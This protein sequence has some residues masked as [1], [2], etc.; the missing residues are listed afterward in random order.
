MTTREDIVAQ[1]RKCLDAGTSV[2]LTGPPGI[3]LSTLLANVV[4]SRPAVRMASV[5][6]EACL[7]YVGVIDL[8]GLLPS[9]EHTDAVDAL[10][11]GASPADPAGELAVRLA[12]LARL[13]ASGPVLLVLD[14]AQWLDPASRAVLAFVAR[15]LTGSPVTMLVAEHG[16][17]TAIDICPPE[18]V[19]FA[20]AAMNAAELSD[21]LRAHT[22]LDGPVLDR[23]HAAS[24]GRIG[25]AI[26]LGQ[27][28]TVHG[29]S[30]DPL[31]IPASVRATDGEQLASLP[32]AS[33]AALLLLAA[34]GPGGTIP[35]R[36]FSPKAI[37]GLDRAVECGVLRS[38]DPVEFSHPIMREMVYADAT[39]AAR[40]AA[41]RRLAALNTPPK[42]HLWHRAVGTA[43]ADE[44]LADQLA[45][46]AAQARRAGAIVDAA[47]LASLAAARTPP[48]PVDRPAAR[49]LVAAEAAYAAGWLAN[50]GR[51][52]HEALGAT[53]N[54]STRTGA[55][56]LLAQLATDDRAAW[57][58]LDDA[59]TGT[60]CVADTGRVRIARAAFCYYHGDS[61]AGLAEI[62]AAEAASADP[63]EAR[64]WRTIMEGSAGQRPRDDH[65]DWSNALGRPLHQGSA[66]T[67]LRQYA[68]TAKLYRGDVADAINAI[69]E[70]RRQVEQSGTRRD[71]ATVLVSE[72]AI[73][74]RAGRGAQARAA[75]QACV[76]LYQDL[77]RDCRPGWVAAAVGELA[78]GSPDRAVR[79]ADAA[80]A[81]S[82]SAGDLEW[83][84][85]AS[86]LVGQ[87]HLVRDD[88]GAAVAVL[89]P[90]YRLE[91]QL[92]RDDPALLVWHADFVEALARTGAGA[93]AADVLATTREHADR[94]GRPVV[95]LG[96]HR[97]EAALQASNGAARE[98][99]DSLRA[100]LAGS[101]SHPYPLEVARAWHVLGRL[102]RRAHRRSAARTALAEAV[103]R[104]AAL[105][106][107]GWLGVA[108]SELSR[109][110]G[111][112]ADGLSDLETRVVEL[113][114][115]GATNRRIAEAVF[116]SVKAVEAMLSN[117]YRRFDVR[118]RAQ[119]VDRLSHHR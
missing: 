95:L 109:L 16:D 54:A 21:A 82:R 68:A 108:T 62:A 59:L 78:G 83:L 20:V 105:D 84:R 80:A 112:K 19:A 96:L 7:P 23:V 28:Q 65:R 85:T 100:T 75:G 47:E 50:A 77:D 38:G 117:L 52:A 33:H 88:P 3:G 51:W 116:V 113:I 8:C 56:L 30:P 22:D 45:T 18:T 35:L 102:E 37:D 31:V 98:A 55:R 25:L 26:A 64:T 17:G 90:A 2:L 63:A 58:L 49:L 5:R 12:T 6:P 94:A 87:A 14:D 92:S 69:V 81:A 44:A 71:L 91:R 24:G 104:Y 29:W 103:D 32:V 34:A 86:V 119:L 74:S 57:R 114:R 97:A 107:A 46:A 79:Y 70:L 27:V 73:Y 110:D 15:R 76:R 99:A 11:S 93:E 10:A 66:V 42:G 115:S 101:P 36:C 1:A 106:A 72:T 43:G 40:R 41:H 9:P 53:T 118:N 39:P 111:A 89:R 4:G 13:R 67:A 60:D 61:E 48:Q